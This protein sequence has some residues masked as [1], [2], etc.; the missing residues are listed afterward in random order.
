MSVETTSIQKNR[1]PKS[2]LLSTS[3]YPEPSLA[4]GPAVSENTKLPPRPDQSEPQNNPYWVLHRPGNISECNGC[5][6][7]IND[8]LI[9]GRVE[10]DYFPKRHPDKSKQW[11]L[12][13][14]TMLLSFKIVLLENP[15]A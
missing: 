11:L 9:I 13:T 7:Q 4:P 1:T 8:G 15:K 5:G 6:E 10:L 3:S 12:N 14:N 2:V